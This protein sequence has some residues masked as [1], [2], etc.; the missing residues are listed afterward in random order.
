[1]T[2]T[3]PKSHDK[4][5]ATDGTTQEKLDAQAAGRPP[6]PGSK[7][8]PGF[9]LG[10]AVTDATAGTGLGLGDDAAENR[11]DQRLPGR[12]QRTKLGLPRFGGGIER[13]K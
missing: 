9:D 6:P 8:R 5:A 4:P 12:R 11:L 1:M 2:K 3:P 13:D 7:D 10:G